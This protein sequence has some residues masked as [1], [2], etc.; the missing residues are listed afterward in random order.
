[1][2][3]RSAGSE[4]VAPAEGGLGLQVLRGL[5]LRRIEVASKLSY[6]LLGPGDAIAPKDTAADLV[7]HT[8]S[9]RARLAVRAGLVP[10]GVLAD[11]C[12]PV[13]TGLELPAS[14]TAR[15]LESMRPRLPLRLS[16]P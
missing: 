9:W 13:A 12:Q 8:V 15:E 5:L 7:P 14:E 6:E 4:L 3:R 1:M 16:C 11:G 2:G 10:V